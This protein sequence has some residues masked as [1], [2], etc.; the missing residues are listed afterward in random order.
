MPCSGAG[1]IATRA[2]GSFLPMKGERRQV[3]DQVAVALFGPGVSFLANQP[4]HNRQFGPMKW[5][6]GGRRLQR[7]ATFAG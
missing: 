2:L 6:H 5:P 4:T 3:D 1:A 7:A